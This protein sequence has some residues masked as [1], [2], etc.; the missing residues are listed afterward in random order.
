MDELVQEQLTNV[1]KMIAEKKALLIGSDHCPG[2]MQQKGIDA[3]IFIPLPN[4]LIIKGLEYEQLATLLCKECRSV[5]PQI[6]LN[7]LRRNDN[8]I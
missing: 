4:H 2:C 3:C 1:S 5:D 7:S 8:G 6:I